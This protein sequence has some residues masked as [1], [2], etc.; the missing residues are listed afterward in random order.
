MNLAIK[1]RNINGTAKKFNDSLESKLDFVKCKP[2][3]EATQEV[4]AGQNKLRSLV[5]LLISIQGLQ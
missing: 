2:L 4:A 1:A 3:L 5:I